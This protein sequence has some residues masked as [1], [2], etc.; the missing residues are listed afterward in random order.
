MLKK[1]KKVKENP[2]RETS[3]MSN[4]VVRASKN[5]STSK[6]TSTQICPNLPREVMRGVGAAGRTRAIEG[7]RALIENFTWRYCT[8]A[9]GNPCWLSDVFWNPTPVG[10]PPEAASGGIFYVHYR[11]L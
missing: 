10:K 11:V 1:S 5:S 9:D 6:D 4:R 7:E 8:T 2:G 3:R